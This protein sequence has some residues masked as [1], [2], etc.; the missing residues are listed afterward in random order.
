VK[1]KWLTLLALM[2]LPVVTLAQGK[3]P[4]I[5]SI[6]DAL[7]ATPGSIVD[8]PVLLTLDGDS[9]AALGAAIKTTNQFL[10]FI[11][12][13][14]G[15]II[16][17]AR[18]SVNAATPD[19]VLLAF[20]DF[21]GG[22]IRNDGVLVTLQFQVSPTVESGDIAKL[23][24]SEL[25]ATDPQLQNLPVQAVSGQVTIVLPSVIFSISDTLSG[26]PGDT[27]A[28]PVMLARNEHRLD[29]LG[30]A[31]KATNQLLSFIGFTPGSII[32]GERF[33]VNAITPDSVHLTFLNFGDGPIANDGVLT[34]LFFRIA[35][36]A[37]TGDISVLTFHDMTASDPAFQKLPA[38]GLSGKVAIA[39]LPTEIRGMK[40]HDLN[41]NGAKDS[42]EPG[43]KGWE[44]KLT[45]A[46]TQ[47]TT[48]DSLSNYRFTSLV[49]RT[50]TVAE[51]SAPDGNKP[52]LAPRSAQR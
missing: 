43:L 36:S 24:F 16:P 5:I 18:F 15:P 21:G 45:S 52:P 9:V 1:A 44:I 40:W 22:P 13:T 7:K 6:S 31:I 48:T 32:P 42:G 50:Y 17:G 46:A 27:L 51:A 28:V 26:A 3:T 35:P 20:T 38:Q 8:V 47:N 23:N 41:G 30:A 34:T 19:S 12:F 39:I 4:V 37:K 2:A 10:S 14:P 11:G 25:F 29:A 33:S 49:P